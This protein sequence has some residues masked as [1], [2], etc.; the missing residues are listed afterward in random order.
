[1][2]RPRLVMFRIATPLLICLA[3]EGALRLF[4]VRERLGIAERKTLAAYQGAPWIDQYLRDLYDCGVQSAKAHHPRYARYVLQDINEDCTTPT[5]NYSNRMRKTWN[6]PPAPVD[7]PPT[8]Y[9]I[10][11]FG[12]STM[13]GQ[14][15]IDE[16]TIPSQFS[17]L[18]NAPGGVVYHVTN[19]GVG[20][21][22]F[23][24]SVYKL[25]ELLREGRRFD[26]VIFYDGANDVDYAYNLGKAGALAEEDL[27]ETRLEGGVW[28]KAVQFGKDQMNACVLCMTA[29]MLAR[30][31]PFLQD[32]LTPLIVK[33]RDA[34]HFKKGQND[35][36]DEEPLAE[37]IA[38]YYADSHALLVKLAAV[39][40]M[41]YLDLWQPSL[42][43]DRYGPGEAQLAKMD[44][45]LTDDKLRRL[46][47]LARRDTGARHLS[48]FYDVSDV[49]AERTH[50]CYLDAVH[51]SGACNG[52][53][54]AR[55]YD[56]FH[57]SQPPAHSE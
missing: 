18:A 28:A 12:G 31:T 15:A 7:P 24:Q 47:A 41:K 38:T 4:D 36:T 10:G 40:D 19:Y 51:L 30:H 17:K 42:M 26:A 21:Y 43:D 13:E 53:V 34:I 45:R 46:Y 44:P 5:V 23:T 37:D 8:V 57:M 29:G 3:A 27:V 35:D 11:M 56:L 1:M 50:A 39:Y 32:H 25:V 9:E 6:P 2:T 48:D 49:L 54:A 16:E 20:A 14:G 33:A 52:V 22:T 55:I